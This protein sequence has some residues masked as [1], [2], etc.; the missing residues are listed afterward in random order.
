MI[1]REH[2]SANPSGQNL[3]LLKAELGRVFP[4]LNMHLC[5][6]PTLKNVANLLRS[7][8]S[9]TVHQLRAH[10]PL[11]NLISP[12]LSILRRKTA[13][14]HL[15]SHDHENHMLSFPH[16]KFSLTS[17]IQQRKLILRWVH[18]LLASHQPQELH[19]DLL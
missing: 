18:G 19:G 6:L 7:N 15:Q 16:Q 3:V 11:E 2:T 10:L 14:N 8:P 5:L 1:Q 4:H 17:R 12:F 13:A 9:K